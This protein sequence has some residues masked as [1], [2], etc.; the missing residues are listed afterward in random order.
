MARA[1]GLPAH[2]APMPLALAKFLIEFMTVPGD[3]VVDMFA[4]SFTTALAAEMLERAWIAIDQMVEY[5]AGGALRMQNYPGYSS[6][7][8]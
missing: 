4:G 2:G 5:V 6:M 1:A 8:H 7:L 3:L